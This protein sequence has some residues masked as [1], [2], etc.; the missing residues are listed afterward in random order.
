MTVP[1]VPPHPSQAT[2]DRVST[3]PTALGVYLTALGT[4]LV[5]LAFFL[6]FL[7]APLALLLV[8][9]GIIYTLLERH[10]TKIAASTEMYSEVNSPDKSGEE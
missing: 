9:G 3:S 4:I 7:V 6:T 5:F 2:Q 1:P 10:H 8:C